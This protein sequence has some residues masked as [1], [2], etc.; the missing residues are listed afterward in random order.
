MLD[1]PGFMPQNWHDDVTA[2]LNQFAIVD[3]NE[4]V[5]QLL[6]KTSEFIDTFLSNSTSKTNSLSNELND[7]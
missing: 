7:G 5:F 1:F 4:K 6:L 3:I 2:P